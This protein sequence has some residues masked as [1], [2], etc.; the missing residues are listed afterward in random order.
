MVSAGELRAAVDT[1][2]DPEL[3]GVTIADL[4]MVHDV[5]VDGRQVIVELLPTFIGC[6]ALRAIADD[7]RHAIFAV[8]GVVSDFA[9]VKVGM[10]NDPV[11]T[12]ARITDAGRA[13]LAELGI[14]VDADQCPLCGVRGELRPRSTFGPTACRSV[15]FC[16]SCRNPV[17]I[18]RG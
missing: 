14:A 15:A 8:P 12:P 17:E 3:S 7:V 9:A 16:E 5:R 6:P 18:M 13:H 10:V 4:G 2:T 1:V 11:W